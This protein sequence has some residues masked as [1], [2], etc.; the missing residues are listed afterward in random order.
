M[1]TL[2]EVKQ[3]KSYAD[4]IKLILGK[5]Y[6]NGRTQDEVKEWCFS[7]Y[8]FDLEKHLEDYKNR[9]VYCLQCGKEITGKDRFQKKFCNNS[10]A[11]KYSNSHRIR[12]KK[13]K[14]PKLKYKCTCVVCGS[15]FYSTHK[16]SIHCSAQCTANDPNV[17]NKMR[18]KVQE[19]INNGTFSGWQSRNITSYPEQFWIKVLDNHNI[20]YIREDFSTKK[21]FLDFVIEKDGKKIDLEID[22]KQH[23]YEDRKQH[24]KERDEYLQ[25]LGYIVYRIEWNS[26]N[27][28][29]GKNLM[30]SKIENFLDFYD[31]L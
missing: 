6:T 11:A 17:K 7:N 21:Y 1:I 13:E 23:K 24:D 22:G 10:C 30:K 25:N 29:K 5:N 4:A 3:C 2:E 28:E 26:I 15:E 18:E 8:N 27:N 19:R 12:V 20:T 9:K 16:H 14:K 31:N